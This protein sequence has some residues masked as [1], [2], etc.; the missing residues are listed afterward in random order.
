MTVE[1][2]IRA[3]T[4]YPQDAQVV[5]F[6]DRVGDYLDPVMEANFGG[7]VVVIK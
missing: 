7:A 5:I 2:L 1:E 6:N 4:D 3:L